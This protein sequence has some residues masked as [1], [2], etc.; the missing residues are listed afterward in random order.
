V[1]RPRR[2]HDPHRQTH[3]ERPNH[4][5]QDPSDSRRRRIAGQHDRLFARLNLH[6]L[7]PLV[8]AARDPKFVHPTGTLATHGVEQRGS[9][10][11]SMICR[12]PASLTSVPRTT[13]ISRWS[14]AFLVTRCTTAGG[15]S[16]RPSDNSES[17]ARAMLVARRATKTIGPPCAHASAKIEAPGT[18]PR[19]QGRENGCG[20]SASLRGF[21]GPIVDPVPTTVAS[22]GVQPAVSLDSGSRGHAVH[23][24]SDVMPAPMSPLPHSCG[25]ECQCLGACAEACTV[26]RRLAR[27]RRRRV[28]RRLDGGLPVFSRVASARCLSMPHDHESRVTDIRGPWLRAS[29]SSVGS[30]AFARAAASATRSLAGSIRTVRWPASCWRSSFD[31]R[32]DARRAGRWLKQA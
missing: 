7:R 13:P 10:G 11:F 18:Y 19:R 6:L 25:T 24:L 32:D 4:Q 5:R 21:V 22:T 30:D 17:S 29:P 8:L 28:Y 12:L 1:F 3:R 31:R 15:T 27:A 2:R 9:Y 16:A 26:V 20:R 23:A 14:L